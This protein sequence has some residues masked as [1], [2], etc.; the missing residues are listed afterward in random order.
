MIPSVLGMIV[1]ESKDNSGGKSQ[2]K[3]EEIACCL[4]DDCT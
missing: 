2:R 1:I 3:Q 4:E